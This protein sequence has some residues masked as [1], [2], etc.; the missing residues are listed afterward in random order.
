M[1][2]WAIL[3]FLLI[4]KGNLLAQQTYSFVKIDQYVQQLGSLEAFSVASITDTLTK[5]FQSKVEKIRAI[6]SWIIQNISIDPKASKSKDENKATPLKVMTS[7]Q[8]NAKGFANLF[9]EMCSQADI[10]CI[11]VEG[12]TR[13]HT[14]DIDNTPDEANHA[15]NVV[16][17]GRSES[18]WLYVDACKGSGIL[19]K[20]QTTFS[21]QPTYQYFFPS[22]SLF[23]LDHFASNKAW[24]LGDG[25][26]SIKQFY[27]GPIIGN[28]AYIIGLNS[29]LPNRGSIKTNTTKSIRFRFQHDP[30]IAIENI[31]LQI[32]EGN[33]IIPSQ[34]FNFNDENGWIEFSYT[35]KKEGDYPISLFADKQLL[36]SYQLEVSE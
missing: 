16:Q 24:Q 1:K 27:S 30:T 34:P 35:F 7:R 9:Q 32:G 17:L 15:W 23:N 10:R 3:L 28:G 26:S 13:N 18:E 4:L 29:P 6:Y 20:R 5:P 14:E 33:K 31:S 19:D 2:K 12:F 25:P 22:N 36:L 11:V 8:A 21:K